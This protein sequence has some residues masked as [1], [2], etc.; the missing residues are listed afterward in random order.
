MSSTSKSALP[1]APTAAALQVGLSDPPSIQLGNG[2]LSARRRMCTM[3]RILAANQPPIRA[4]F[5]LPF[6]RHMVHDPLPGQPVPHGYLLFLGEV[7]SRRRATKGGGVAAEGEDTQIVV[8]PLQEALDLVARGE[9]IDAKTIIA[10]QYL[11][12]RTRTASVPAPL[13]KGG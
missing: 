5:R 3:P 4:C 11:A 13:T 10:L 6:W 9:I 1:A 7:D 8:L 2:R 12:L